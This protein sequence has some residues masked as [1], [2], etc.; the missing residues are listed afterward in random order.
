MELDVGRENQTSAYKRINWKLS[1][2]HEQRT[3]LTE[4]VSKSSKRM[5]LQLEWWDYKLLSGKEE[6]R[7][8]T[9]VIEGKQPLCGL[10]THTGYLAL[11]RLGFRSIKMP[12][13]AICLEAMDI[14]FKPCP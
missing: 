10:A 4:S 9:T 3:P 11:D 7:K 14:V 6:F 5:R 13:T 8:L 2:L 12:C 1:H